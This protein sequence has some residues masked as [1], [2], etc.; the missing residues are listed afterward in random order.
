MKNNIIIFLLAFSLG[1]GSCYL[2]I[3]KNENKID[4]K[5]NDKKNI[6]DISEREFASIIQKLIGFLNIMKKEVNNLDNTKNK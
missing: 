2:F 6:N 4:I 3:D 5:I 1:F